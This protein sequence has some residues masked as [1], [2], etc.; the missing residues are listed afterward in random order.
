MKRVNATLHISAMI[1]CPNDKCNHLIELFDIEDLTDSG[2]LYN[3]LLSNET[4]FGC[5]NLDEE[6]VCPKCEEVFKVG[7]VTW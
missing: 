5:D 4:G 2:Y 3:E 6:I 7:I 1:V